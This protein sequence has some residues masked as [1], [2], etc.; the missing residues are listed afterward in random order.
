MDELKP[1]PFCGA[2]PVIEWEAWKEISETSGIYVLQANHRTGCF[3]RAM[4][5]TNA[6]ARMSA[7]CKGVL[8]K[9][10]NRRI[11]NAEQ[12]RQTKGMDR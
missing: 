9:T 3:I 8:Q 2:V 6:T 10:W 7:S 11:D 12:Q 1:C 5:G 4:N